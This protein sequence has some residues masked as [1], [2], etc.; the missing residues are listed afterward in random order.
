MRFLSKPT[1]PC[2]VTD[3]AGNKSVPEEVEGGNK[4]NFDSTIQ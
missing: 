3:D 4:M 2:G 1:W